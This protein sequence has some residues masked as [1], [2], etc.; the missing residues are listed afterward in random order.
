[1]ILYHVY[2]LVLLETSTR[3]YTETLLLKCSEEVIVSTL[4]STF[5]SFNIETTHETK[6]SQA[7]TLWESSLFLRKR[8]VI[9][10]TFVSL[11]T[12]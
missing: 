10:V 11:R 6:Y 2:Y 3:I 5:S 4:S 8:Q 9:H 12:S 1:M 7:N